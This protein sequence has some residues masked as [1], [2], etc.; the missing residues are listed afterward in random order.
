M[1]RHGGR[2]YLSWGCFF[3]LSDSVYG[4]PTPG[5]SWTRARLR[6]RSACPT[7]LLAALRLRRMRP[8]LP[9]VPPSQPAADGSATPTAGDTLQLSNCTTATATRWRRLPTRATAAASRS[10]CS[11]RE[12]SC[13]S[14]STRAARTRRRAALAQCNSSDG[15]Q[16]FDERRPVARQRDAHKHG[17]LRPNNAS[18]TRR[19]AARAATAG[20]RRA[21]A[22][23]RAGGLQPRL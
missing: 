19:S 4:P 10:A 2:Y 3:A 20:P 15:S 18:Y 16:H 1:H 9:C 17:Q 21:A 6:L 22:S 11:G 14:G 12:R 5:R 13:A 8:E 7:G 23:G